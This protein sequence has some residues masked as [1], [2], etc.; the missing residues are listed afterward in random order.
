MKPRDLGVRFAEADARERLRAIADVG[1]FREL[2]GP[3]ARLTSPHLAAQG[4][5]AQSDDGVVVGRGRLDGADVALAAMTGEFL[6]G[7]LGEVG[8]AKIAAVLERAVNGAV[9]VLDSGG[10]RLQEANLGI[11]AVAEICDAIVALRERAPVIAVVAGRVGDYGGMA[12]ALTL[13]SHIVTSEVARMGL[14]GP[15]VIEQEAGADEFDASNRVLIWRTTGGE[16]RV[17][18]G[19]ADVLAR[20]SC[21][22]IAADVRRVFALPRNARRTS[23]ERL[24][25]IVDAAAATATITRHA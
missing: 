14:N 18:Q 20:D 6:G 25:P 4:L 7:S 22:E 11:L 9:L 13:C 8:G 24:R 16:R 17:T 1:T 2:A 21:S 3:F 23:V 10:I 15:Q 12:I 19:H 5:V